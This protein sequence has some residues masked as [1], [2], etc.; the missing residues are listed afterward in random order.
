MPLHL[1]LVLGAQAILFLIWIILAFR[2]L[3]D[4][5]ADAVARSGQTVPGPSATW[6]AFRH[7]FTAPRY[8]SQRWWLGLLTLP[9]LALSL[10]VPFII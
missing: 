1:L 2:W 5:R 8:A 6:Q 7:G 3:F 10:L 4:I 9:L